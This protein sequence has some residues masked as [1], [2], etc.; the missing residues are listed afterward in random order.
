MVVP[1]ACVKDIHHRDLMAVGDLVDLLEDVGK[2][3][4]GN[5]GVV[6]VVVGCDLGD[7][8]EC[9]LAA[10]P[11]RSSLLLGAGETHVG[12]GIGPPEFLDAGGIDFDPTFESFDLG[13]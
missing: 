12:G 10:L 3:G 7:G 1:V 5:D 9:G 13:E 8:T 2:L 11:E 4:P 6:Q